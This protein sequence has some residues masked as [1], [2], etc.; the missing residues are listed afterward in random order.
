MLSTQPGNVSLLKR[1]LFQWFITYFISLFSDD[2]RLATSGKYLTPECLKQIY[3]FISCVWVLSARR[4]MCQV[5]GLKACA[6]TPGWWHTSLISALGRSRQSDLCGFKASVVYRASSK[7]FGDLWG[8]SEDK[9]TC[10][11][12]WFVYAWPRKWHYLEVW[13]CWSR[14]VIVDIGFKTLILAAWKPV[15][16]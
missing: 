13:P 14:C 1:S 8:G 4:Y 7:N 12:R 3:I 11:L 16:S 5:L 2:L 9:G 10:S 6:T 15:F